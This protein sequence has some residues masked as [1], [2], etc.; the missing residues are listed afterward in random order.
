[1]NVENTSSIDSAITARL[2]KLGLL[3]ETC[4]EQ[5]DR[6][7]ELRDRLAEV[8]GSLLAQMRKAEARLK[9]LEDEAAEMRAKAEAAQDNETGA[10][11]DTSLARS[12]YSEARNA[13]WEEMRKIPCPELV[14]F[15]QEVEG[16][17]AEIPQLGRRWLSRKVDM[18]T[19]TRV[20]VGNDKS[21]NDYAHALIRTKRDIDAAIRKGMDGDEA[22]TAIAEMKASWPRVQVG[23]NEYITPGW[24]R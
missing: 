4:E 8:E 19:G 1:M 22:R 9:E 12:A 23:L 16:R 18:G 11:F 5:A 17:Q 7:R 13:V 6:R 14:S 21:L 3:E 2:R 20:A 24:R 15:L 10:R